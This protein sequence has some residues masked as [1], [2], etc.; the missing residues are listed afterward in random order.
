[1]PR[2]VQS[3]LYDVGECEQENIMQW[4]EYSFASCRRWFKKREQDE[5]N[6]A[7]WPA[8]H[9]VIRDISV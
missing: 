4:L 3:E 1:M 6:V 5:E 9:F 2:C 8:G 7:E